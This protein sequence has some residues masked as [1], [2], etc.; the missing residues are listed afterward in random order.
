MNVDNIDTD[1]FFHYVSV[2]LEWGLQPLLE[3]L[4]PDYHPPAS[5]V[6]NDAGANNSDA[7]DINT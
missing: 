7:N 5:I 1:A 2:G 4:I 6:L 3:I